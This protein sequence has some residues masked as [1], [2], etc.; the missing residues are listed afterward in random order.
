MGGTPGQPKLPVEE[1]EESGVPELNPKPAP[2][3]LGQRQE[4]VGRG[5]AFTVK[6]I[7]KTSGRFACLVHALSISRDFRPSPDELGWRMERFHAGVS[8]NLAGNSW[9]AKA[10]AWRIERG[11]HYATGQPK[12]ET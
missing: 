1:V 8:P 5:T 3:E 10:A 11:M 4:E 9:R 6:E 12:R 7:G 2:I